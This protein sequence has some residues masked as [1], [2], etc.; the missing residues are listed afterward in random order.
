[1]GLILFSV[2]CVAQAQNKVCFKNNCFDVEVAQ[3]NEELQKG[4]QFRAKLPKTGGMLF[5]FPTTG[6]YDFWMKDT[7]ISLDMI[8]LDDQKRV[9]FIASDVPPCLKDPC[10]TYGPIKAP[11]RYILEINAH[12]ANDFDIKI[13]DT[14]AF[15]LK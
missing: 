10:P 4:L 1:M 14:A 5:I 13:G 15:M 6:F 12:G 11:A 3:T 7:K 9:V 8:W 2:S